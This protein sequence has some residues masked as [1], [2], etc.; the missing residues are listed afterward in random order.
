MK[1]KYLYTKNGEHV[2]DVIARVKDF[3]NELT[4]VQ[5]TYHLKLAEDLNLTDEGAD[6]LFDYIHNSGEEGKYLTFDEHI[7]FYGKSHKELVK[8]KS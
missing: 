3:I 4:N 5:E 2:D 6:W 8:S 1:E 7:S